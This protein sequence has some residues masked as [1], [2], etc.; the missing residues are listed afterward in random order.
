MIWNTVESASREAIEAIQLKRLQETARR[1]YAL[2]PFYK[3]K[4]EER[5]ITPEDIRSLEDLQRL[6]FTRKQD[7][8]NHYPFGLFC[9]PMSEVVR[10]HSS[11]GT[12]GKPT[13]VGYNAHDMEVWNEVMARVYTMSGVG[14]E[15]VVHNAYGYGLFTGGL[16]FHY[17]AEK[18]GATVVPASGGFTDRQLM[19]MRDFGATVLACTPSFA[20]HLAEVAAKAGSE[21]RKDY[22][23]KVGIFGAE[24]TSEGLKKE[25]AKAWGIEYREVYGLS[26]IIGPGVSCSCSHSDRLHLFEDHFLPEIIDPETGEVLPEGERGELVITTLSKQALPIIR[27]RTG[28]ITSLVKEPCG[29]GRTMVR[30]ESIVGRA[31]DMLIVNGVNVYPSQ[32]EHVI[33]NAEGVTLNYQIIAEKKGHLDKLEIMVEVSEE[34]MTDNVGELERIRKE[35]QASLL[36]NLYIN[37]DVKLVEP[38]T[39]ERSMGKAVRVVDKRR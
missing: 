32:V 29:C 14:A 18:V 2:N 8:R 39:I 34:I 15:D 36:N 10:I 12:T 33:A 21:F 31:D 13:V 1:V 24:P 19:L 23:L 25:V 11:S 20:L 17:G 35:I 3:E 30:M 9:V 37:A 22:K 28:D 16:G 38:N 4:F 5:G 7:L 6:P 27:Y 26:E